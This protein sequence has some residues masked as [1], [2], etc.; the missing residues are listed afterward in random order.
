MAGHAP[1]YTSDC[2]HH[3]TKFLLIDYT[4]AFACGLCSFVPSFIL[5]LL[6]KQSAKAVYMVCNVTKHANVRTTASVTM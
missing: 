2:V 6:H 3:L 1:A 5:A 4:C